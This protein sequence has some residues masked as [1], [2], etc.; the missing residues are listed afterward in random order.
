MVV[1]TVRRTRPPSCSAPLETTVQRCLPTRPNALQVPT[2]L[3]ERML[4]KIV[5]LAITAQ[6]AHQTGP[7]HAQ[8]GRTV[9]HLQHRLFAVQ[10]SIAQPPAQHQFSVLLV[11]TALLDP[12]TEHCV[13]LGPSVRILLSRH[14]VPMVPIAQLLE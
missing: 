11:I 8:Q 3:L 9:S 10:D 7:I 2:V 6:Q 13:Q 4:L 5:L 12:Q 14:C 1:S